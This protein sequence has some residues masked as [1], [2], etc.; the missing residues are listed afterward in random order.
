MKL[1]Q[2]I[3]KLSKIITTYG[4]VEVVVEDIADNN[5]VQHS[6]LE[7]TKAFL[8]EKIV[9]QIDSNERKI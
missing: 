7:I 8:E 5:E 9:I 2:L 3:S 6:D 4:D 1:S